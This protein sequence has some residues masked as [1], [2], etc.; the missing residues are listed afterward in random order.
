M[1]SESILIVGVRGVVPS[2]YMLGWGIGSHFARMGEQLGVR[3]E[4]LEVARLRW[5]RSICK[6]TCLW[7]IHVLADRCRASRCIAVPWPS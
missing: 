3:D 1:A 4:Q 7:R 6:T 2:R 5:S